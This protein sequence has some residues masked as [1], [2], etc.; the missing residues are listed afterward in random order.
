[1]DITVYSSRR[2]GEVM[3]RLDKSRTSFGY[4]PGI[5]PSPTVLPWRRHSAVTDKAK[6]I[7]VVYIYTMSIHSILKTERSLIFTAI[8]SARAHECNVTSTANLFSTSSTF[9][10]T[11]L[12]YRGSSWSFSSPHLSLSSNS[13]LL[14]PSVSCLS[15]WWQHRPWRN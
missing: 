4:V 14:L 2:K 8:F 3:Q 7:I 12:C 5:S 1:M 11:P 10:F 15:P 13:S 9:S 6:K